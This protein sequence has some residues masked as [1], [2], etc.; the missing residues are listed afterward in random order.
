[1]TLMNLKITKNQGLQFIKNFNRFKFLRTQKEIMMKEIDETTFM[2]QRLNNNCEI[3]KNRMET[4]D[5][6]RDIVELKQDQLSSYHK[7][8]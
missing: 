5:E 3:L 7:T 6:M 8:L 2:I 4:Y 1:M